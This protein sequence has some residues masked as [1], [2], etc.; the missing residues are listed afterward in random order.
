MYFILNCYCITLYCIVL[1]SIV[2]YCIVL[3][4]IVLYC[5]VLYC[6]IY[7][8]SHLSA[9]VRGGVADRELGRHCGALR[10]QVSN[11]NWNVNASIS[12]TEYIHFIHNRTLA[13]GGMKQIFLPIFL[14]FLGAPYF[15]ILWVEIDWK[16]YFFEIPCTSF[17]QCW[18]GHTD[19]ANGGVRPWRRIRRAVHIS[20]TAVVVK[21]IT[22]AQ[23][24]YLAASNNYK[25]FI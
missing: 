14:N 6:M 19:A 8:F 20:G 9:Q 7:Y 22:Q 12:L 21:G 13:R 1:Y 16:R 3:Y 2:L 15:D 17:F 25:C 10:C 23:L 4:C 5:I 18:S 11:I 24:N